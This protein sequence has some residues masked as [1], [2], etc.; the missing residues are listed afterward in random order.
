MLRLNCRWDQR[1][2]D[3]RLVEETEEGAEWWRNKTC[4]AKIKMIKMREKRHKCPHHRAKSVRRIE[5]SISVNEW[6]CRPN[7]LNM[8]TFH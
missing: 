6:V 2:I 5:P 3:D 7:P 8:R 1:I 4:T